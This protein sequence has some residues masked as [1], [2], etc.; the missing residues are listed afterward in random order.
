MIMTPESMAALGAALKKQA[1]ETAVRRYMDELWSQGDLSV[2]DEV[3]SEDF[4]SHWMPPG[5]GREFLKEAV[6]GYRAENPGI[7]FPIEEL[8]VTED[9]VFVLN[10]AWVVPE[11]APEGDKG[12]Q[13]SP[14]FWQCLV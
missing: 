12:E 2:V 11:G 8:I 3:V 10:S 14:P 6:A 1:N 4:V 9:K 5:E 13:V 7:Y